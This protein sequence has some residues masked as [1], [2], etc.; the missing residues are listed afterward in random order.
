MS[1]F[2]GSAAASGSVLAIFFDDQ[3]KG[4]LFDEVAKD[5][6]VQMGVLL[7]NDNAN[8]GKTFQC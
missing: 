5:I 6:R 4:D 7:G 2:S 3:V 1:L 8:L